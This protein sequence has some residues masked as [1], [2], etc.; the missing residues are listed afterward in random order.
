ME[1]CRHEARTGVGGMEGGQIVRHSLLEATGSKMHY[2]MD[3][4]IC[5]QENQTMASSAP[6]TPTTEIPGTWPRRETRRDIADPHV[7]LRHSTCRCVSMQRKEKV[8]ASARRM[9]D[10]AGPSQV[11]TIRREASLDTFE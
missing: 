4:S 8:H 7:A 1:V 3:S 2:A 5:M 10:L 11:E 6:S 9:R